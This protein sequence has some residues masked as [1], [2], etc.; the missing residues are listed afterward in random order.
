[1]NSDLNKEEGEIAV[2]SEELND[3]HHATFSP[4]V[5]KEEQIVNVPE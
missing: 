2:L 4:V 1:M 3:T 5:E